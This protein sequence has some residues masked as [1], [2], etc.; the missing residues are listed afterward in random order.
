MKIDDLGSNAKWEVLFWLPYKLRRNGTYAD[1][2]IRPDDLLAQAIGAA[3]GDLWPPPDQPEKN[4]RI[5]R[6]GHP[7]RITWNGGWYIGDYWQGYRR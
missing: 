4:Y 7:Q 3:A 1:G 6:R 5:L 2:D